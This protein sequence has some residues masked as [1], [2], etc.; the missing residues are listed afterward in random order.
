MDP[1]IVFPP[2]P[3]CSYCHTFV[4]TKAP[5]VLIQS[6]R[7]ASTSIILPGVMSGSTWTS[8]PAGMK[9]LVAHVSSSVSL[10]V[11][12]SNSSFFSHPAR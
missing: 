11:R 3:S 6:G 2:D 7:P 8:H 10:S 9:K 4:R 12:P 1:I 5:I